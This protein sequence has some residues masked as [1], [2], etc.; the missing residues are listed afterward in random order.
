ME[1]MVFSIFSGIFD[2]FLGFR[3]VLHRFYY[4]LYVSLMKINI[5]MVKKAIFKPIFLIFAT[6]EFLNLRLM[7]HLVVGGSHLCLLLPVTTDY[8]PRLPSLSSTPSP[9][10]LPACGTP[11]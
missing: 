2:R 4:W 1:I 8:Y 10:P 11:L 6:L 7:P 5:G 9:C 3:C